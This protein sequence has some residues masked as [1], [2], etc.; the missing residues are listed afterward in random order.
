VSDISE[1]LREEQC[2]PEIA[3]QEDG[4]DQADG[5]LHAHSRSTPFRISAA[6]AKN[7]TV[8]ITNRRSCMWRSSHRVVQVEAT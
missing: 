3:E 6:R 7:A 1:T 5:V 8:S 4:Y 2:H